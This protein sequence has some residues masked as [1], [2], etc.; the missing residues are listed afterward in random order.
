MAYISTKEVAHY[1]GRHAS[2]R[3]AKAVLIGAIQP[4]MLKAWIH[5][6]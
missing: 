1:T 4:L 6:T 5:K 3:V 2:K